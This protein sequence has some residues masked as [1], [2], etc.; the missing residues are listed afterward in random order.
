MAGSSAEREIRDY[1]AGRLRD[2]LP[3]S[4]IIHELVVG[5]CRADLAAVQPDRVTLVEIKSERDKLDR[6]ARQVDH[7]TRAGHDVIVIAHER[8]FDTTPYQNGAP[9]FFP[10]DELME[11]AR[12]HT[13]AIWAYPEAPGRYLY[14]EWEPKR[15]WS[16]QPEPHA[17]QL[18]NLMWKEEMLA[19]CR[20][21]GL[22]ATARDNMMKLTRLMQLELTGK[23]IARSV[24]RQLRLREFPEADAPMSTEGL[25]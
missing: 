8:W 16:E 4:R 17:A 9:R 1:A 12:G 18:L 21:Y 25:R 20:G 24:C 11:A 19:E 7:F 2:M 14:G 3:N 13:R 22:K 10:S 15:Y 23:Q 5:G 6:L